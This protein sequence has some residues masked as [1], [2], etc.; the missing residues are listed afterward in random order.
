MIQ[1][2]FVAFAVSFAGSIPPGSINISVMQ[3]SVQNHRRAALFLALGASVVEFLYAGITVSF[4][5]YLSENDNFNKYF[6]SISG[7]FLIILGI[8]NILSKT[9]FSNYR[10]RRKVRGRAGLTKGIVLGLLNPMTLPFWLAVT[11]YL[12]THNWISLTGNYFWSYTT[13]LTV[14][15]FS[16]LC[17]VDILGSRFQTIADNRFVVHIVPG[18]IFIAMGIFNIIE[19]FN[20]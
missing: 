4:Y 9:S 7:G 12:M 18:L 13:G 14:G 6:L 10:E 19:L 20:S 2:F 16:L 8:I 15:T 11:S 17:G 1:T 3:M 5:Q